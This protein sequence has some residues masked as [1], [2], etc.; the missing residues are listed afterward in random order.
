[1]TPVRGARVN[2]LLEQAELQA[3]QRAGTP[4]FGS[5]HTPKRGGGVVL[6]GTRG[7]ES[8]AA[9]S[10]P[11]PTH[12]SPR[13][14]LDEHVNY[15]NSNN[16]RAHENASPVS[17]SA[18]KVSSFSSV[19]LHSITGRSGSRTRLLPSGLI[20]GSPAQSFARRLEATPLT[21]EGS[22]QTDTLLNSSSGKP[23]GGMSNH[24]AGASVS[25]CRNLLPEEGSPV[26]ALLGPN[27]HNH[28]TSHFTPRQHQATTTTTTPGHTLQSFARNLADELQ[29]ATAMSSASSYPVVT[30][31]YSSTNTTGAGAQRYQHG[32]IPQSGGSPAPGAMRPGSADSSCLTTGRIVSAV[33]DI[34]GG[35]MQRRLSDYEESEQHRNAAAAQHLKFPGNNNKSAD[36][37]DEDDEHL[38]STQQIIENDNF[39]PLEVSSEVV[40]LGT[41]LTAALKQQQQRSGATV[42]PTNE[43]VRIVNYDE[44]VGRYVGGPCIGGD[45]DIN[46]GNCNCSDNDIQQFFPGFDL[47]KYKAAEMFHHC[48]VCS[49]RPASFL[50]LN[51]FQAVCPSHVHAH[52][53]AGTASAKPL[54]STVT[55]I[56]ATTTSPVQLASSSLCFLYLNMLDVEHSFDRQLWCERCQRFTWKCCDTYEPLV[57]QLLYSKGSYLPSDPITDIHMIAYKS[58]EVPLPPPG[59]SS[60]SIIGELLLSSPATT[61]ATSVAVETLTAPTADPASRRQWTALAATVQGWRATQEDAEVVFQLNFPRYLLDDEHHQR[62]EGRAEGAGVVVLHCFAV[63]DGHGG[64]AVAELVAA[65]LPSYLQRAI[66]ARYSGEYK[67]EIK[68][69]EHNAVNTSSQA[70]STAP[71]ASP[72]GTFQHALTEILQEGFMGFD[73]GL[74]NSKEGRQGDFNCV[75][76]TAT[77][78]GAYL[79]SPSGD[80]EDRWTIVSANIGDS[81]AAAIVASYPISRGTDSKVIDDQKEQQ[82]QFA[83]DPKLVMITQ[84]HRIDSAEDSLRIKNA[85]YSIQGGRIEGLLAVPRAFGDF[86]FKQCGGDRNA[87]EQAVTSCPEVRFFSEDY[88]SSLEGEDN[89][90]VVASEGQRRRRQLAGIVVGCDGLWDSHKHPTTDVA[91]LLFAQPTAGALRKKRAHPER[92]LSASAAVPCATVQSSSKKTSPQITALDLAEVD[93][94]TFSDFNRLATEAAAASCLPFSSFGV[95]ALPSHLPPPSSANSSCAVDAVLNTLF[96]TLVASMADDDEYTATAESTSVAPGAKKGE[97]DDEEVDTEAHDRGTDNCSLV[98]AMLW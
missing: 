82:L 13:S 26:S 57:E 37:D 71:G 38:G 51:C 77:V 12:A 28:S 62:G 17:I 8:P 33:Q 93:R 80:K 16:N 29:V 47:R 79:S 87:R 4:K 34:I 97:C 74:R 48:A 90:V 76:C 35:G 89:G 66:D 10:I 84:P 78:V 92:L 46:V 58:S 14:T 21:P 53:Q 23:G 73:E 3:A 20:P 43:G 52:H 9:P 55:N 41:A 2:A 68:E 81:G 6:G 32:L 98:L 45:D 83:L 1:M 56:A 5:V 31:N 94:E 30:G 85:G 95:A 69:S 61:K 72:Q 65:G 24:K 67:Q 64:D 75:G 96:G 19:A 25:S 11:S 36:D 49:R 91:N 63:F 60:Q 42:S 22:P 88:F 50:C 70:K 7:K 54:P 15:Y 18:R 40:F 86:D 44:E 39:I 59:A 27:H